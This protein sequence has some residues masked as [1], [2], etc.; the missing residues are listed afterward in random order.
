MS[1]KRTTIPISAKEDFLQR[2]AKTTPIKAVAELIW[3][4]LDAGSDHV[5]VEIVE[6]GITGIDEISV[7]DKGL[8]I[9]HDEVSELFGNL[10][11]SWKKKKGRVNGRALHGKD[12]QGR[13][14][15]FALGEKVEWRTVYETEKNKRFTFTIEGQ[16]S[17]LSAMSSTV[18]VEAGNIPTGTTV[19]VTRISQS[20]GSLLSENAPMELAKIFAA[21]L[22]RYPSV[23]VEYSGEVIDPT[24]LLDHSATLEIDEIQLPDGSKTSA[25][26]EVRE[27]A[28]KTEREL[29]LCDEAGISLHQIEPGI[30]APGFDFTA[31]IK[32]DHFR[33]LDKEN[34]LTLEDLH[35]EVN[36]IVNAAKRSLRG[37]FRR[38]LAE[39][40]RAQ[41]ERW[42]EEEIYPYADST[43]LSPLQEV[44]RQVFDILAVNLESYL[45]DFD[46]SATQ[47]RK[48]TFRLLS[49]AIK[50]NPES[51]QHIITEVLNLKKDEQDELSELMEKTSLFSIISAA[52]E[53]A[54]RLNFLRGL[55]D[56]IF[57][58]DTKAALLE[59]DQL[60]KILENEAWLFDEN[61]NISGS[62]ERLEEVLM[63]HIG[64]LKDREDGE[65]KVDV[66]DGKTG[67]IDL[68]FN[69]AISPR[70]AEMDYLVVELKRPT[71]KIDAEVI[72]QIKQYAMAVAGDER[73]HG[74]PARWKFV[75]VSN[76]MNQFAKQDSDQ[77]NRPAGLVWES[78]DKTISVW[79]REWAEVI[80]TA[81]AKLNFV[82]S[83]LDFEADRASSRAYLEKVHSKFLPDIASEEG[84]D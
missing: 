2:Q 69:R 57:D 67:R 61:F 36:V 24:A 15:A 46:E 51:V 81:K 42:K 62:E 66:G 63:K 6:N 11:D 39:K 52:S 12:G 10:G 68:M 55:H 26:V 50:D 19:V 72:T 41:V 27:W 44:E 49:Q 37:Y 7:S 34:K 3:N 73:F 18:P 79:V 83:T 35:P 78:N 20:L 58:K 5:V 64:F 25:T 65:T 76:E 16:F 77:P 47:S 56:L 45:P 60:H 82:N 70:D 23:S 17:A 21:Y 13:F 9:P 74:V 48:F 1:A 4:G 30:Q 33:E 84:E 75:A 31:Y 43:N 53:I 8:G 14:K 59:R 32:C 38:R 54:N 29:H 28:F 40:Q 22:S 80:N 71:K